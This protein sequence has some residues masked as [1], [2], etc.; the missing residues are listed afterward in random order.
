MLVL[1]HLP[2]SL[3]ECE[4]WQERAIRRQ[5]TLRG[6]VHVLD[7]R[8]PALILPVGIRIVEAV[9]L[10]LLVCDCDLLLSHFDL[11]RPHCLA[12]NRHHRHPWWWLSLSSTEQIIQRH[13]T[14]LCSTVDVLETLDGNRKRTSVATGL[15]E[16]VWAKLGQ[17][18]TA[19]G[20]GTRLL[21][22]NIATCIDDRV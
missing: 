11:P 14:A 15:V 7:I 13:D 19:C 4:L 5:R 18:C 21:C 8:T 1:D 10:T 20:S 12:C 16:S 22:A 9:V 3:Q 6:I 17:A 2:F